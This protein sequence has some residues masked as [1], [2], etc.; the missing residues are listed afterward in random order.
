MTVVDFV[1]LGIAALIVLAALYKGFIH[2]A[3]STVLTVICVALSFLLIDVGANVIHSNE[4]LYNMLL[5]YTEG[6][7]FIVDS[8]TSRRDITTISN[9]ELEEI[10]QKSGLP[11]H[12]SKEI[13]EN[14]ELEAFASEGVIT[15]GDYFNNTIVNVFI[16][17]FSF[18]FWFITLKVVSAFLLNWVDYSFNLP[19]FTRFDALYSIAMSLFHSVLVLFILFMICPVLITMLPFD[20]ITE[21]IEES[22][23]AK[24]FYESNFLLNWIPGV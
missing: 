12:I 11:F 7:E 18:L 21:V 24:L 1:A 23:F 15:L 5:Y 9:T 6:S 16:N 10:I 13:I 4:E 17:L 22:T 20:F 14:V 19:K 2:T 3:F 8:E